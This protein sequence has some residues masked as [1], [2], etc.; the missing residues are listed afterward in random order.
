MKYVY[1]D[2]DGRKR[3][4]EIPKETID[5][6]MRDLGLT[7]MEAIDLALFDLGIKE[8]E[9][10][11]ALTAKAKE[12]GNASAGHVDASDPAKKAS[13]KRKDPVKE[14]LLWALSAILVEDQSLDMMGEDGKVLYVDEAH[15]SD[16]GKSVVFGYGDDTF[17]LKL[18]RKRIS[19]R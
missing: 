9:E 17:E 15:V 3:S 6:H 12:A 2:V 19:K 14:H 10:A 7:A 16:D 13:A 11:D 5:R 18:T 4:V 8:S 1:R